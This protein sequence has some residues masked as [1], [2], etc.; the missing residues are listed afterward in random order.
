MSRKY[1]NGKLKLWS[2]AFDP[3]LSREQ[4]I[5]KVPDGIQKDQWVSFIDN[6][7]KPEYQ[8]LCQKNAEVR[9][10]QTVP[11]TS[12]AKLLSR[13]QHE[14]EIELGRPVSRVELYIACH[15]KKD[16]SYVNEEARS[17]GLNCNMWTAV[18]PLLQ[19][20]TSLF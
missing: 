12:G 4:L 2:S 6:R 15:K 8:E 18:C 14:M 17:I 16:G 1:R 10:R 9:Q 7:L 3:S 20:G 19:G 11:H 5:A 13:K